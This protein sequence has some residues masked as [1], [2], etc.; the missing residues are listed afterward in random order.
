[1]ILI[2]IKALLAL[3]IAS[4]CEKNDNEIS[5]MNLPL[6][7]KYE[8]CCGAEPVEFEVEGS[9]VYIPNV[10]LHELL[11]EGKDSEDKAKKFKPFL[12]EDITYITYMSIFMDSD[13]SQALL[14]EQVEFPVEELDKKAWDGRIKNSDEHYQGGFTYKLLLNTKDGRSFSLRG[15]S[16]SILCEP[17]NIEIINKEGCFFPEQFNEETMR[18]EQELKVDVDC[19]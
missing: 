4:G 13:T 11:I 17:K 19:F 18:L 16:C 1:M 15:K 5:E 12:S 7:E 14:Y 3:F 9:Y 10:F 8:S 6:N 2:F